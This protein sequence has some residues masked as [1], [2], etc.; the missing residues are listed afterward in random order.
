MFDWITSSVKNFEVESDSLFQLSLIE[1]VMRLYNG[2]SDVANELE[3]TAKSLD[4]VFQCVNNMLGAAAN[5]THKTEIMEKMVYF[6]LA[7]GLC[8]LLRTGGAGPYRFRTFLNGLIEITETKGKEE[9][10]QWFTRLLADLTAHCGQTITFS[11]SGYQDALNIS[12]NIM[13]IIAK[14]VYVLSNATDPLPRENSPFKFTAL[15]G[16]PEILVQ[17]LEGLKITYV[18]SIR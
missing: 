15:P 11:P 2:G 6:G 18:S 1:K 13:G 8:S 4:E 5:K 10:R 12:Y 16:S 9:H 14:L 17:Q 7:R 3:L